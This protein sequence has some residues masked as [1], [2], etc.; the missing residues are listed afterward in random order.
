MELIK[1]K[2][3]GKVLFIVEGS[4]HEFTLIKKIFGD[5]L[6][7]KRIEKRRNK[8]T[9]YESRTDSHSVVA[10]INTR[11]SNIASINEKDYLDAIYTELIER[12]SFD[13][14]NAAV[15]YIFDRDSKSNTNAQFIL[16]LLQTL[17]NSRENE[18]NMMG[19]V[20]VLSY[21]CIE[22][23]EIS[24]F[25]DKSYNLTAKL[26]VDVKE[27]I[28]ENAKK[29][30]INKITESS[31]IH[32]C[33]ELRNYLETQGLEVDVDNFAET[34]I[35]VFQR[36]EKYFEDNQTYF[37]LSMMSYILLDLGILNQEDNLD[38]ELED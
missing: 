22:A 2:R 8:A 10:V 28:S 31:I 33:E 5:I 7:Y 21:P 12:Y 11:T 29:I 30:S 19:G 4:R 18:D 9:Y 32:A 14:T 16:E 25:I 37:L 38:E 36:E 6:G 13:V 23:Y 26:G 15:Y 20:L 27:Y 35:N 24:N 34:N 17:R 1:N 3:I